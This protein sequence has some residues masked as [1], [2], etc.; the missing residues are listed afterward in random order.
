M[1][2]RRRLKQR[3]ILF[4]LFS[5]VA[6]GAMVVCLATLNRVRDFCSWSRASVGG[7]AS[8]VDA[9]PDTVGN[10]DDKGA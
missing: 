5:V 6:V 3:L 8:V 9:K 1:T 2:V 10:G 4:A 7:Q